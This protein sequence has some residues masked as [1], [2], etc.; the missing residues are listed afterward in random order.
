MSKHIQ[1]YV[2]HRLKVNST[3]YCQDP[4]WTNKFTKWTCAL[5]SNSRGSVNYDLNFHLGSEGLEYS[6][7]SYRLIVWSF[8]GV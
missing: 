6:V 8:L 2:L 1:P 3:S 5:Y 7:Q 4:K